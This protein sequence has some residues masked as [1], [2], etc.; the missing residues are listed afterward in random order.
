MRVPNNILKRFETVTGI[1]VV[2]LSDYLA[3]RRNMSKKRA[4]KLAQ[5]SKELGYD[6]KAE[7]WM[8]CPEKIKSALAA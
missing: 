1:S 2:L 4:L 5:A 3:G 6:F 8:F 7:N